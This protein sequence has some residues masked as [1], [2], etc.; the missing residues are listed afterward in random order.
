M[1]PEQ[2]TPVG[3]TGKPVCLKDPQPE[4][5]VEA[6]RPLSKEERRKLANAKYYSLNKE[7]YVKSSSY[8]RNKAQNRE[9]ARRRKQGYN[10]KY[11][12]QIMVIY[13]EAVKLQEETGEE[14]H[15]DHVVPLNGKNVCGLHVPWN[16]QILSKKD[17]LLKSNKIVC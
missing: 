16:L 13:K 5:V 9:K 3:K 11:R 8:R 12:E 15:V 14:F 6:V 7:K 17:N 2:S 4:K 1:N 10:P